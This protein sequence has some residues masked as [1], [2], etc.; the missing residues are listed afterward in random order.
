MFF[1]YIYI[2]THTH[3]YTHIY[4]YTYIYIHIKYQSKHKIYILYLLTQGYM[5]RLLRVIIRPSEEPIQEHLSYHALWDPK[6][7]QRWYSI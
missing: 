2:Y 1:Q 5:F 6:C 7:L 3:I 4:I